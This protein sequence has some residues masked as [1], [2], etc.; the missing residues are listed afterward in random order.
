MT[1]TEYCSLA[2]PITDRPKSETLAF[3]CSSRRMLELFTS[4]W[5]SL[6]CVSLG[7]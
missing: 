2:G 7:S 5:I 1:I 3:H 6:W 4:Q